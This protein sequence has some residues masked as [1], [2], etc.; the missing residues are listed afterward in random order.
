MAGGN[1]GMCIGRRLR[2]R[3]RSKGE[4]ARL[5]PGATSAGAA[6]LPVARQPLGLLLGD[7]IAD[8]RIEDIERECAAAEDL[9]VERANVEFIA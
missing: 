9:I 8:A 3:L 1:F 2:R 5:K 6:F 4:D 7:P